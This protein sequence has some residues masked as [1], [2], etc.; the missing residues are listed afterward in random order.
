M[1]PR[2]NGPQKNGLQK[3]GPWKNGP[4]KIGPREKWSPEKWSP[5]KRVHRKMVP[6]KLVPGPFFSGTIFLK[7]FFRDSQSTT[8]RTSTIEIL[9]PTKIR[10]NSSLHHERK[11]EH[12]KQKSNFF[13]SYSIRITFEFLVLQTANIMY[14]STRARENRVKG[15]SGAMNRETTCTLPLLSFVR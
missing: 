10:V 9:N 14:T 2:K 4:R 3:N 1:V 13:I 11:K 7:T 15:K 8:T 12:S 5:G 6:G